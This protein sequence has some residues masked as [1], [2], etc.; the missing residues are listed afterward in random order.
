MPWIDRLEFWKILFV[1][2]QF[3]FTPQPRL[4]HIPREDQLRAR[5]ER[6]EEG[7]EELAVSS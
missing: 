2:E 4:R 1:R 6:G 5:G 7:G 3:P